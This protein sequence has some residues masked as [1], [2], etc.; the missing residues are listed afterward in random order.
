MRTADFYISRY[1]DLRRTGHPNSFDRE[2]YQLFTECQDDAKDDALW[3]PPAEPDRVRIK[4]TADGFTIEIE[5]EDDWRS[6]GRQ[7]PEAPARAWLETL[8]TFRDECRDE[9]R[10]R[11]LRDAK[12]AVDQERDGRERSGVAWNAITVAGNRIRSLQSETKGATP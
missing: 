10:E 1:H 6:L 5:C 12:S 2:L 7:I 9:G 11:G 3:Q 4:E 8:Y